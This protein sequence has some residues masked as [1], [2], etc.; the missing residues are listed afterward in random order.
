MNNIDIYRKWFRWGIF[1]LAVIALYGSLMRYKI[2]FDFPH[3]EQKNLLHAHSHFAF[4]AW[5]SHAIYSGLAIIIAPVIDKIRLRKYHYIIIANLVCSFGMLIAFTI[6]G[7]KAV[8]IIFSSLTIVV[9]VFYALMYLKD[10]KLLPADHPSRPWSKAALLLNVFSAIGPFMLAYLMSQHNY[11]HSLTLGSIYLFLHFQY[12]GWFFFG[13]MAIVTALLPKEFPDI[14]PYFKPFI[15]TI[16]PTYF[17]SILWAKLPMWIYILTVIA[18]MIQLVAW[19]ALLRKCLPAA[20]RLDSKSL[21]GWIKLFFYS[22]V[23]AMTLKFTLQ[24][25]SV[26]PSLSQFVYGF[27]SIVIAYLHLVSLGIYSLFILGFAFYKDY[28]RITPLARIGTI[29]FFCGAL[30]NEL[31]LALQGATSMTY[32]PIPHINIMLLI[33]ALILFSSAITLVIS[34]QLVKKKL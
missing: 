21:P 22:A 3:F 29:G 33:A 30:L 6:Q 27:R 15:Y 17:L 4:S 11:N 18:T 19:Y 24:A 12:N 28:L 1:N 23:I 7:Y 2:A 14:K 26:I 34:Q 10:S 8:S 31:T 13:V 9:S 25:V 16:I 32:T 5:I 20:L